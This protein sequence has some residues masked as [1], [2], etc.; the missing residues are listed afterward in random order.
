MIISSETFW[1]RM[2][3]GYGLRIETKPD[4]KSRLLGNEGQKG[5]QTMSS[6]HSWPKRQID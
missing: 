3:T 2:K 6:S 1:N 4:G 5:F